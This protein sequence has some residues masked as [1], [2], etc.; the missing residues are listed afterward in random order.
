MQALAKVYKVLIDIYILLYVHG[1]MHT[2]LMLAICKHKEYAMKHFFSDTF[3]NS[4][5]DD[6]YWI[7]SKNNKTILDNEATCCLVIE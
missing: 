7:L 5:R 1:C 3:T 6:F 2:Y 4:S